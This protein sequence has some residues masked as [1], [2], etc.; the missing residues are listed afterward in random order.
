M[1]T[2]SN[3]R[4]KELQRQ[5]NAIRGR[6][7]PSPGGDDIRGQ[8]VK[9]QALRAQLARLAPARV[10]E[11]QTTR[12]RRRRLSVAEA[13]SITAALRRRNEAGRRR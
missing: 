6:P 10:P 3:D 8:D 4:R 2:T 5:I 13:R 1:T 9:I 11:P 12:A 7:P